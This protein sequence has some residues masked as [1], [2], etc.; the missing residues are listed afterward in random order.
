MNQGMYEIISRKRDGG[1]LSTAT[2]V[3]Y[4]VLRRLGF[5]GV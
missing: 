1:E 3:L 2:T 4:D 5:S